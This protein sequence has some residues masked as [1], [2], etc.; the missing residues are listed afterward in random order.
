M[1]LIKF[2][3]DGWN[4]ASKI[5]N[6]LNDEIKDN[7]D[8]TSFLEILINHMK[9]KVIFVQ[10]KWCEV[11]SISDLNVYEEEIKHSTNWSH[12]WRDKLK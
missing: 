7:I 6:S 10:G 8:M 3:I 4:R 1:G 2:T 5:Y 9:I 12:D 11:D